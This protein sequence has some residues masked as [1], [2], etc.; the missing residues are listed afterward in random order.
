MVSLVAMMEVI[1]SVNGNIYVDNCVFINNTASENGG[2][3]T[4]CRANID[5]FNSIF[6]NNSTER[7]GWG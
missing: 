2:A 4:T 6:M 7:D 3:I 1:H 5:I